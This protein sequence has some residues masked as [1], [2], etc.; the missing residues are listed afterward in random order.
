MSIF[1]LGIH[2]SNS[3]STGTLNKRNPQCIMHKKKKVYYFPLQI[4]DSF[5]Q[6]LPPTPEANKTLEPRNHR[7]QTQPN[8]FLGWFI[9]YIYC[10]FVSCIRLYRIGE[11]NNRI[12][13]FE[14]YCFKPNETKQSDFSGIS[15]CGQVSGTLGNEYLATHFAVVAFHV[16]C[17]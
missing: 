15:Q 13:Y 12:V 10:Y 7:G 3:W 1:F 14:S 11:L 8:S 6:L 17:L 16:V 4:C 9:L 5:S 2:E